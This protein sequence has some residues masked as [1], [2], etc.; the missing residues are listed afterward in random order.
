MKTRLASLALVTFALSVVSP[1]IARADDAKAAASAGED[2]VTLKNGGM[3]RG[4]VVSLEPGTK[5]VIQEMGSTTPRTIPWAEVADVERGKHKAT[6]AA[7]P[8]AGG[9]GYVDPPEKLAGGP[10]VVNLHIDSPRPVKLVEHLGTSYGQAGTTMV[11]VEHAQ[12]ACASPCDKV[13]DGSRGQLF[14]IDGDG[15]SPSETFVLNDRQGDTVVHVDPGSSALQTGGAIL[16][17]YLGIPA[18][19]AGGT[20]LGVGAAVDGN[21]TD[22]SGMITAGAV[23]LV[24]GSLLLGGGIAMMVAGDTD[25]ELES[26]PTKV[27]S[28]RPAS[29]EPRYWRGEF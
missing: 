18:M 20:F 3:V 4:T 7:E 16:G 1:S 24:A 22:G 26:K 15:V 12:V 25:V 2:E 19:I 29:V 9:P 8:G 21:G 10:G 28:H 13:I 5:V 14:I 11:I 27:S 17:F 23:T 6:A